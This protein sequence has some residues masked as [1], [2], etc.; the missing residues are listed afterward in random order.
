[1]RTTRKSLLSLLL[2]LAMTVGCLGALSLGGVSAAEVAENKTAPAITPKGEYDVWD[3]TASSESLSQ[4][5]NGVYLIQSAADLVYFFATA[6]ATTTA[7]TETFRLTCDIDLN[8]TKMGVSGVAFAGTLD[9]DGHTVKNLNFRNGGTANAYLFGTLTGVVENLNL[10]SF[11]LYNKSNKTVSLFQTVTGE[12]AAIRN[13]HFNGTMTQGY[14]GAVIAGTLSEGATM[15]GVIVSGAMTRP[16]GRNVSIFAATATTGA[17]FRGCSNYMTMDFQNKGI[18]AVFVNSDN[19][20]YSQVAAPKFYD[21]AN[22]ADITVTEAT[23]L[24]V[25]IAYDYRTKDLVLENCVNYGDIT[26]TAATESNTSYVGGIMAYMGDTNT[27][28]NMTASGVYNFGNIDAP[29]A[30][31]VGG[32]FAQYG[33]KYFVTLSDSA[34]Y[35]NITGGTYAGGILGSMSGT[36]YSQGTVQMKNCANYG[37]VE[38]T[39]GYAGAY[40]GEFYDAGTKVTLDGCLLLGNVTGTLGAASIFG[41]N[42]TDATTGIYTVALNNT[43]IKNTLTVAEGG[44]TG[45]LCAASTRTSDDS[46]NLTCTDSYISTNA[47]YTHYNASGVGVTEDLTGSELPTNAL[48]DSTA[49]ATLNSYANANGYAPWVQGET[50]PELLPCALKLSA[51]NL[52]LRG[53]LVMNMK[54]DL[55]VVNG[56]DTALV[57]SV[58]VKTES[59]AWGGSLLA[60]DNDAPYYHF[61]VDGLTAETFSTLNDYYVVVVYNGVEYCSLGSTAYS[62]I[63][64]AERMY[65]DADAETKTVLESII[66]YAYYAELNADGES[67]LLADFNAAVGSNLTEADL[68]ALYNTDLV[69][70]DV[71]A[72]AMSGIATVG[73]FLGENLNLVFILDE[74]VTGLTMQV[75]GETFTYTPEAGHI[76]IDDLHAGMVRAKLTLTFQT[77]GGEVTATYAI[78][79]YLNTVAENGETV[80]QQNLAK[81]AMLYMAAARD[82]AL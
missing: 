31:Y 12:S 79:N 58:F 1:M 21:C 66:R 44:A 80:A 73:S 59:G 53:E 38:A 52:T 30:K 36:Q 2:V 45:V 6:A 29:G 9:G 14:N 62:P 5:E 82:Y 64:Y 37:D 68:D 32:L 19:G 41:N 74:S 34:N 25:F 26:V 46:Y 75:A 67:N 20:A 72:S 77:E 63:K 10:L 51:A 7:V 8:S 70:G 23:R 4:D 24:G 15:E 27:G 17:I 3:G 76:V 18:T 65:A 48:T 22:Y 35:G 81:A 11:D 39:A 33:K 57:S 49:V 43:V 47:A 50:A 55:S 56:L 13:C 78:S 69:R 40:V 16:D 71:D 61:A 42:S 60:F 54:M 28:F